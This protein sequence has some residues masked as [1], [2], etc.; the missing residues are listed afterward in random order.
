MKTMLSPPALLLAI[1]TL[2]CGAPGPDDIV[3]PGGAAASAPE[4]IVDGST[5]TVING[6]T[7]AWQRTRELV[8]KASIGAA[9]GDEAYLLGGVHSL[10]ASAERIYLADFQTVNVRAYDMNGVHLFDIGAQGNGPGEFRRPWAIGVDPAGRLIV[11]DQLQRRVHIFSADGEFVDDWPSERG[12]RTTIGTDGS[13]YV[14]RDQFFPE[15]EDGTVTTSMMAYGPDGDERV[16]VDFPQ[17][18][19]TPAIVSI[20]GRN[21]LERMAVFLGV[22]ADW[23][24]ARWLPFAP[25]VVTEMAPDGSMVAARADVYQ[26]EVI[27]PD[28]S[29]LVV[30]KNRTAVPIDGA[31]ADWYRRRL[32]AQW[33]AATSED[34]M[35]LGE[36][37]GT[38]KGAFHTI[39]PAHDGS[40]WVVRELVG[41]RLGD[42]NDSPDDFFGFDEAPCWRQ[43][44]AADIFD[45]EGSY[46]GTVAMPD[47]IRY[48]VRPYIR[49]EVFI[50]LVED[51]DSVARVKRFALA[52]PG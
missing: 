15:G 14:M 35:W 50:A 20:E 29:T 27:R 16:W 37:I 36:D 51:A 49:G 24:S 12:I 10:S 5:T 38:H 8:E 44:Y 52:P 42:C 30:E 3:P 25:R 46:L 33:R 34:W 43:P 13:V 40:F 2:A 45:E 41:E 47:G 48:D 19:P 4:V 6:D 9:D 18:N 31:E 11:R 26:F 22:G 32:T 23:L 7:P 1:F 21:D 17:Q 28:G 39:L